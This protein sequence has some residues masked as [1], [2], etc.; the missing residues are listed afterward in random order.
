MRTEVT[1]FDWDKAAQFARRT[2]QQVAAAMNVNLSYLGDQLGLYKTL[3]Q[4]G[5]VTS[6]QFAKHTGFHE[7]WLREWL[8]HQACNEQVEYD[9]TSD[10]FSL[11][12]EAAAVLCD[13]D[14]PLYFAGGFTAF[15]ATRVVTEKL[16]EIFK[17]GIGFSYDDH[18]S[19]CACGVERMN[20]YVPR[21]ALV[22]EIL[23]EISGLNE[24]L[25]EG[26]EVA[27]VG[28]GAAISLLNMAK[29]F[30]NSN[31]TGYEVSSHALSRARANVADWGL[32]NVRILDARDQPLP[33]D[34]SI[35]F[36]T[37]FDVVH[38]TPFPDKLIGDIRQALK[39]N[40]VWLC[41]DIRSFPTFAENLEELPHA[42]IMYGF[43]LHVC[44][45]SAMSEEGGAGLGTL[46][47]N[48]EVA[49]QMTSAAGFT[50]FR[51]LDF[52]NAI[53]NFYEIRP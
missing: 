48:E 50:S 46:G 5:P 13:E 7:R 14:S 18:G 42:A 36:I 24:L 52:E 35:D 16:P 29:S 53:N 39:T 44:M 28:C 47:F 17:T 1:T 33:D 45:S 15:A 6:E 51:R 27:D 2:G 26:I 3:H 49:Q 23:P 38:D 8:R 34:H 40:G 4:V 43:S 22:Q 21:F 19:T 31:F 9:P 41:S 37:T 12:N 10:A 32:A 25:E 11:S 20:N 30:P